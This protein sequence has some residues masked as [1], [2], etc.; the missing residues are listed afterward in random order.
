MIAKDNGTGKSFLG[1]GAYLASGRQGENPERVEWSEGLNL[2]TSDIAAA[3]AIM[4]SHANDNTR[5]ERPVYHFSINWHPLEGDRV[6]QAL[7]MD[8]MRET[9]AEL[10]LGEH[11][12]LIVAH[13]DTAHFHVHAVVNRIH[14]E[15]KRSWKQGLSK[16]VLEK[17][18]ARLSL[19]HGF[20]IVAGHH[21]A[22]E[23]GV[24]PPNS[25]ESVPS[26]VLRFEERTGQASDLTA[27]RKALLPE[28]VAARSWDDLSER[29]GGK[30]YRIE[31][32]GR[33][34][35]FV[36]RR[37]NHVKAS[38]I[39]RQYSRGQLHDRYG[40]SL[41][42]YLGRAGE[43]AERSEGAALTQSGQSRQEKMLRRVRRA[44]AGAKDWRDLEARLKRSKI[45]LTARGRAL[46]AVSG[47]ME[48]PITKAGGLVS[49]GALE[50]QFGER[51]RDYR[52]Q[53]RQSEKSEAQRAVRAHA[54][55]NAVRALQAFDRKAVQ[56]YEI[57]KERQSALEQTERTFKHFRA[58]GEAKRVFENEFANIY[59]RPDKAAR[60]FE[61]LAEKRSFNHAAG[62][63]ARS[64]KTFGR[65]KGRG[66]LLADA[67]RR[68]VN[69]AVDKV[70]AASI[71]YT[72]AVD[73]LRKLGDRRIDADK[74]L[75]R[76]W[77]S[78]DAIKALQDDLGITRTLE[79]DRRA[80]D[81]S[82]EDRR[83]SYA[84]RRAALEGAVLKAAEG[85]SLED[86][87][88]GEGISEL[89]A[90][91]VM[92]TVQK[93][94]AQDIARGSVQDSADLGQMT[95]AGRKDLS[96][97]SASEKEL[98]ALTHDY[99]QARDRHASA[100]IFEQRQSPLDPEIAKGLTEAANALIATRSGNPTAYLSGFGLR[101]ADLLGDAT[102]VPFREKAPALAKRLEAIRANLRSAGQGIAA[103]MSLTRQR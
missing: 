23:L 50:A 40:E 82:E 1:I 89:R 46:K 81:P 30:G 71:G 33:G 99:A 32:S 28:L 8:I 15:T 77:Q 31:A 37:G 76:R 53:R 63:L 92:N 3:S 72:A 13:K 101:R 57:A 49:R 78:H 100:L 41:S 10:G 20:E 42:E 73:A 44:L 96:K 18:M 56:L 70:K 36:D 11:Q 86:V 69:E 102:K 2:P 64:P 16:I 59:R 103:G 17:T 74:R 67:N 60:K 14:P 26:E 38:A 5:V 80:K 95:F 4:R 58:I 88:R 24:E 21:N 43:P 85:V 27:A 98:Y 75:R 45:T 61:K 84:G 52:A 94:R 7:A 9:L 79:N 65:L 35:S 51:Y 87:A 83:Q 91:S 68:A 12:S 93:L 90:A 25:A 47:R 48:V 97:A 54:I 62:A 6:D 22:E 29:V 19:K 39:G 66:F 55:N 34:M